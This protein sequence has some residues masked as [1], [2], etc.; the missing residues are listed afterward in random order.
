MRRFLRQAVTIVAIYAIALNVVLFGFA[1]FWTGLANDP[2]SAICHS[3]AEPANNQAPGDTDQRSSH[4]CQHCNLCSAT[5][6]PPAP[7]VALNIV[8]VPP[9]VLAVLVPASTPLH[10][11]VVSNPRLARGPPQQA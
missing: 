1:S 8:L 4:S 5:R 11:G 2:F 9:Q 7:D 3:I 10:V 6:P